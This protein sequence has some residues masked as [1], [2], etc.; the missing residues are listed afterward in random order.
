M[1]VSHVTN[2]PSGSHI[3]KI[4]MRGLSVWQGC[5]PD[6]PGAGLPW[7]TATVVSMIAMMVCFVAFFAYM[8]RIQWTEHKAAASRR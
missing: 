4:T 6:V 3:D 5:S 7:D 2:C 8:L 1:R